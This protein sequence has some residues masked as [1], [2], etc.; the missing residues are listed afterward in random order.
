MKKI[1]LGV[2]FTTLVLGGCS[3]VEKTDNQLLG[4][5]FIMVKNNEKQNITIGFDENNYSGFSGVN[6]Y[7]GKYTI[8]GNNIKFDKMGATMMAGPIPQ[9]NAEREY[10]DKLVTVTNYEI[11]NKKLTLKTNNGESLEY[12]QVEQNS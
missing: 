9:M 3:T 1:A 6:N 5:E 4:K 11:K 2:L 8:D 12:V 7:F 10:F